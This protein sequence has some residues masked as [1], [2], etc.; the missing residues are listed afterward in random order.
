[1]T[2]GRL[3]SGRVCGIRREGRQLCRSDCCGWE[4]GGG[5]YNPPLHTGNNHVIRNDSAVAE[6][7]ISRCLNCG[8]MMG[9]FE[10]ETFLLFRDREPRPVSDK[11]LVRAERSVAAE[12]SGQ[13]GGSRQPEGSG[14]AQWFHQSTRHRSSTVWAERYPGDSRRARAVDDPAPSGACRT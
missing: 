1:M 14:P 6:S 5:S 12:G 9:S 3:V 4:K 10:T 11:W 8:R 2:S 7:I 13:A